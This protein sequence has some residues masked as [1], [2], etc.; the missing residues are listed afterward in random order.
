LSDS[1]GF[2]VREHLSDRKL[3]ALV[4]RS[5][6]T[7]TA[8]SWLLHLGL[9]TR[10][11]ERIE[12]LFGAEGRDF[13]ARAV[14][15]REELKP[16]LRATKTDAADYEG[17]I[18]RAL[19]TASR[20]ERQVLHEEEAAS[21]LYERLAD[22][23]AGRWMLWIRNQ[24]QFQTLGMFNL[25]LREARRTRR[26]EPSRS[27]ELSRMA[28]S[29]LPALSSEVYG[30]TILRDRAAL[31]WGYL[32]SALR[33]QGRLAEADR[34]L[35]EGENLLPGDAR[36]APD[37][38]AWLRLF[39]AS[40]ARDQR[41]FDE[42]LAAI[43]QARRL[44]RDLEDREHTAW[45][46]VMTAEILAARGDR[47]RSVAILEAFLARAT[48]E[49]TGKVIYLTALQHLTFTLAELGRGAEA[50]RWMS[51]LDEVAAV[52]RD[53]LN[54]ARIR[55]TEGLVHQAVGELERAVEVYREV[56]QVF[57]EHGIA[58]DAALVSLDLTAVLLELGRSGEAR[59][60]TEDMVPIFRGLHVEREAVAA[61]LLF[62]ESLR[63]E[64]ATAAAA[65]ALAQRLK[66]AAPATPRH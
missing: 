30:E 12:A 57:V 66:K 26:A 63:R 7:T 6:P 60:L 39:R 20:V 4:H 28:L 11:Q 29:I 9:C 32:G 23:P 51:R 56:Q 47:E 21:R 44:F 40:L 38:T 34:A 50:R 24:A 64:Q 65:K 15:A 62:V 45:T 37:E 17:A 2:R 59:R 52:F 55:W 54:Q 36:E 16:L 48:P 46:E 19:E 27:E 53:P 18:Q 3:S 43:Y 13:L 58:F 22:Q 8:F 14:P 35:Q 25:V 10:C 41:R 1:T 5:V 33:A 42:A 61:A 31:A 49:Q